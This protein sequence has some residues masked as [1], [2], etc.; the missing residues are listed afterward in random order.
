MIRDPPPGGASRSTP[1]STRALTVSRYRKSEG[2][3]A[4]QAVALDKR[5]GLRRRSD[6]STGAK[7]VAERQQRHAADRVDQLVQRI[8]PPPAVAVRPRQHFCV[9]TGSPAARP[10]STCGRA[11]QRHYDLP[12]AT[13]RCRPGRRG[14]RHRRRRTVEERGDL[15]RALSVHR[16]RPE[17][18]R[19][20]C[21]AAHHCHWLCSSTRSMPART[22]GTASQSG[23]GRRSS[24]SRRD[25][26]CDRPCL[27]WAGGAPTTSSSP[28]P[29][30]R[31]ASDTRRPPRSSRGM[32]DC[33]ALHRSASSRCDM[34]I[35]TRRS[36]TLSAI[37]A[38]NQSRSPVAMRSCRR[39]K[40]ALQFVAAGAA[41]RPSPDSGFAMSPTRTRPGTTTAP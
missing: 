32:A 38:K 10:R 34:F 13:R 22:A 37:A 27:S 33:V 7:R 14:H 5:G 4:E 9:R 2:A 12:W 25:H 3:L 20:S 29:R 28:A 1:G 6:P 31:S 18:S 11:A 17:L 36:M 39:S 19:E 24:C 8:A 35:A 15:V 21:A 23:A 26:L 30:R 16:A 40:R 41:T